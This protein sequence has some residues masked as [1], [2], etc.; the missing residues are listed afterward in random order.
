MS[1][2]EALSLSFDLY[3]CVMLTLEYFFG[4]SDMDLKSE[5]KR[6]RKFREKYRFDTLTDGEMR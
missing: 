2:Y 5:A 6:K 1:F 3:I 4:R